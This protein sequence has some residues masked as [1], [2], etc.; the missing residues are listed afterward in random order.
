MSKLVVS[1]VLLAFIESLVSGCLITNCP[2]G[3]KRSK[4]GLAET[5]VKPCVSCGP[6]QSGQ[7][8]GPSICCGPFGCLLGTPETLRCQREGFFHERE[9]CIAGSAPCRKNT[10]RCAFDGIC[11]S[12]DSCHADKTCTSDEKSRAF[13]ETLDLYSLLNYQGELGGDK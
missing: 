5:S 9:P 10:G 3:G 4:F 13:P 6:G 12:Q 11:C 8:F 2:R 7:C 1:I